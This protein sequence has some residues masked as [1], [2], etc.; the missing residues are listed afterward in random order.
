MLGKPTRLGDLQLL[1][2]RPLTDDEVGILLSSGRLAHNSYNGDVYLTSLDR[3]GLLDQLNW[4]TLN[5]ERK[6]TAAE[7][8][9]ARLA[10]GNV[11]FLAVCGGISYRLSAMSD[12]IDFFVATKPGRTWVFLLR[13]YLETRVEKVR[14]WLSGENAPFCFSLVL[15]WSEM[16]ERYASGWSR[17]VARDILNSVPLI[18]GEFY[19]L[20]LRRASWVGSLYPR[21]YAQRL[22]SP[23][24]ASEGVQS[25]AST[26][27]RLV[28][29]LVYAYL[30]RY[31]KFLAFIRNLRFRRAHLH[32]RLFELKATPKSLMLSSTK[33][34]VL[35]RLYEAWG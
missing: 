28:N 33:Y 24:P 19:G 10:D 31:L 9:A 26:V 22:E 29:L 18:G 32:N 34:G 5:A 1:L 21:L 35:E 14:A 11:V 30:S 8:L 7:R 27:A 25:S 3:A 15:D 20:F 23:V 6:L 13:A 2:P 16:M 4:M 12:D 17:L